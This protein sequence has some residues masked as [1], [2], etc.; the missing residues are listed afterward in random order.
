MHIRVGGEGSH[1]PRKPCVEKFIYSSELL[2]GGGGGI[3]VMVRSTV[4]YVAWLDLGG[5]AGGC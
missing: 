3:R 5:T 1:G 4:L 2:C